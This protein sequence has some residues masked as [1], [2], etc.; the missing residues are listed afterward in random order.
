MNL[1]SNE[2]EFGLT[3]LALIFQILVTAGL[4][5]PT[6]LQLLKFGVLAAREH[7]C[8]VVVV[9]FLEMPEPTVEEL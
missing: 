9:A 7:V 5:L 6:V 4:P 1:T 2:A 8:V 3:H